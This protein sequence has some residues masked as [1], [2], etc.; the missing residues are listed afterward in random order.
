MHI[1]FSD[2]TQKTNLLLRHALHFE[3]NKHLRSQFE[4]KILPKKLKH[5]VPL[6][7]PYTQKSESFQKT[8]LELMKTF[9]STWDVSASLLTQKQGK[10]L[11]FCFRCLFC[12]SWTFFLCV[13]VASRSQ[14]GH[15][16]K[17][18]PSSDSSN[19]NLIADFFLK[20]PAR[21]L[22]FSK[23]QPQQI[24]KFR[25]KTKSLRKTQTP[26]KV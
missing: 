18:N 12:T 10:N 15:Q 24:L 7:R 26:T 2:W 5:R 19:L 22:T 3:Q 20:K 1:K 8:L 4:Q 16:Q 14:I 25:R 17:I 11:F 9:D 13:V 21:K 6:R 23:I